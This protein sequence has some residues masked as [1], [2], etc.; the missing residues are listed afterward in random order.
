MKILLLIL[1]ILVLSAWNWPT[2]EEFASKVYDSF[3]TD[4]KS[5]LNSS[6]VKEGSIIPDKVF[7]DYEDHSYPGSV[8]KTDLWLKRSV[9]SYEAG[10]YDE[11]SLALGIAMHYISDSFAAPHNIVGEEYSLHAKF[12]KEAEDVP[13]FAK[14]SKGKKDVEKYLSEAA[15]SERDWGVWLKKKD[16]TI[17]AKEL[18]NAL[19]VGYALAHAYYGY[20]CSQS[21]LDRIAGFFIM[22]KFRFF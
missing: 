10:M 20:E 6:L 4:T 11:A 13:F 1:A 2:H 16:L 7:Q 18:S 5:N 17:Q 8:A 21:F 3:P 15:D 19:E 14:C 9:E 12:E 22:L